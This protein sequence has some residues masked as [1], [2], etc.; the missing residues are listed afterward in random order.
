MQRN[1]S[2][3]SVKGPV[4]ANERIIYAAVKLRQENSLAW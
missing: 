2:L 1:L 4:K 3:L